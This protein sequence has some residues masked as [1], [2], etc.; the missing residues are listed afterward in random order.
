MKDDWLGGVREVNYADG[1]FS[2]TP[3][4]A[5][6][7]ASRWCPMDPAAPSPRRARSWIVWVV[8]RTARSP[9]SRADSARFVRRTIDS[10]VSRRSRG[11]SCTGSEDPLQNTTFAYDFRDRL[12]NRNEPDNVTT[13]H[14]YIGRETHTYDGNG[15][16]SYVLAR[17][18]GQTGRDT[19][20]TRNPRPG[21]RP[22]SSMGPSASCADRRGRHD[23]PEHGVRRSRPQHP[24]CGPQHGHDDD[25]LQRFR[26]T[27]PRDDGRG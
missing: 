26:R 14:E 1:N 20:T 25:D 4:S 6:L 24:T 13:R 23:K 10:A 17:E 2:A 7:R 19:R 12:L 21:S 27:A 9:H 3:R 8:R 16:H 15:F 18:D 5:C 22:A 11:R